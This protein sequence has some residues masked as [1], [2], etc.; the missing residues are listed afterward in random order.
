MEES[1]EDMVDTSEATIMVVM[2]KV[3]TVLTMTILALLNTTKIAYKMISPST[4]QR[5]S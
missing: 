3:I 1:W 5:L 2:L 4:D